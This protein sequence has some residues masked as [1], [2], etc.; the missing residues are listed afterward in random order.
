M[1]RKDLAKTWQKISLFL[2][3]YAAASWA[4]TQGVSPSFGVGIDQRKEVAALFGFVVCAPLFLI[5]LWFASRYV[6]SYG[7]VSWHSRVPPVG[8]EDDLDLSKPEGRMYQRFILFLF[9][10]FPLAAVTHFYRKILNTPI[11]EKAS[12]KVLSVWDKPPSIFTNID[13]HRFGME[14]GVSYLPFYQTIIISVIFLVIWL[15]TLMYLWKLLS[16]NKKVEKNA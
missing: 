5:C 9:V 8:L 3:I 2:V 12:S 7:G 13:D 6:I 4:V 1:S 10:L 14:G 15:Y 16:A 11:L